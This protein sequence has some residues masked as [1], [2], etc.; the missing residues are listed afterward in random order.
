MKNIKFVKYLGSV[1][2][3]SGQFVEVPATIVERSYS[4]IIQIGKENFNLSEEEQTKFIDTLKKTPQT[5]SNAK[6][7]TKINK[8]V[9]KYCNILRESGFLAG[10][11][12]FQ[13]TILAT[14][15]DLLDTV[16]KFVFLDPSVDIEE[17]H[18][19]CDV[20][21][22]Q[23]E[24]LFY[25]SEQNKESLC[26]GL[27]TDMA[28]LHRSNV[29][30][31]Q[32]GNKNCVFLL[33]EGFDYPLGDSTVDL[34]ESNFILHAATKIES[35]RMEAFFK[36]LYRILKSNGRLVL[37]THPLQANEIVLVNRILER[38]GF[39]LEIPGKLS[40]EPLPGFGEFY[41]TGGTNY[42]IFECLKK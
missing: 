26:V 3:L 17:T 35:D 31:E 19:I 29:A 10:V 2:A 34:L 13:T 15:S 4:E 39:T 42:V 12:D 5:L 27:D 24:R 32:K 18:T 14:R 33:V 21:C 16:R 22:G 25:L 41:T 28:P 30:A 38:V 6:E 36:E 8:H 7:S 23:A 1:E 11:Y 20:G 37:R 9:H 40:N